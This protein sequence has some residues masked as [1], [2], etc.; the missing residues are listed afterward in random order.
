MTAIPTLPQ[1]VAI[2]MD[3]NGRWALR[4]GKPRSQGHQ[5][6]SEALKRAVEAIMTH[7]IRHLTVYAFS[8]ENWNRPTMEVRQLLDLFMKALT[9]EV[10]KLDEHGVCIRFIGD[11]SAF[12]RA[13]RDGMS[14][15]ERRTE[16][17]SELL[18]NVAVNY[19]GRDDILHAARELARRVQAGELSL[20]LIDEQTFHRHLSLQDVPA[21]DLLIRTGG[22]QRLSNFLLWQLA[23][24]ELYFTDV[25]WPDFAAEHVE[26]ALEDFAS[27][28]RR[29]GGLGKVKSA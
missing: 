21:P 20:D 17:N 18:L 2:V 22:E 16:S 25:L 27:R 23:Y 6:G 4:Q 28:E 29:F 1:H 12:N 10:R 24:T 19:G 7:K 26:A 3:G 9:R 14:R 8:S 13:L 5:A 11:R 15:A